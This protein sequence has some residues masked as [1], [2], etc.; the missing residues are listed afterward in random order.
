MSAARARRVSCAL[1]MRTMRAAIRPVSAAMH[2][3]HK[4]TCRTFRRA[5]NQ[6]FSLC[7][8]GGDTQKAR[9]DSYYACA[10]GSM[11]ATGRGGPV[12]VPA[13]DGDC[14]ADQ[15]VR[16]WRGRVSTRSGCAWTDASPGWWSCEDK[17][18]EETSCIYYDGLHA[19]V[20]T[21][22]APTA[23]AVSSVPARDGGGVCAPTWAQAASTIWTARRVDL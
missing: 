15:S 7:I 6:Q 17:P 23:A 18:C 19:D 11:C 5:N 13:R 12:P 9:C 3:V 21:S 22:S 16:R 20:E 4:T 8:D 14:G 10:E 1:V 2:R